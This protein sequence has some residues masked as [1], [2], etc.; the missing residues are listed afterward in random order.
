MCLYILKKRILD[1]AVGGV[2]YWV[3]GAGGKAVGKKVV[4]SGTVLP[5]AVVEVA[6]SASK[7]L[8]GAATVAASVTAA[9]ASSSA[10]GLASSSVGGGKPETIP[11]SVLDEVVV[12]SSSCSASAPSPVPAG[13]WDEAVTVAPPLVDPPV[14][15]VVRDEL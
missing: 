14:V 13:E 4:M 5:S 3:G 11:S 15:A 1:K 2:T 6:K 8:V 10:K 7:S 9:A 12:S